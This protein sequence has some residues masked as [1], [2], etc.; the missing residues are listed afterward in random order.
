MIKVFISTPYFYPA[1]RAGGPVQSVLN[2]VNTEVEGVRYYVFTA[3]TDLNNEKLEVEKGKWIDFNERTKVYYS[4]SDNRSRTLLAEMERTG[5]ET[6]FIIGVFS[7]HFTIVPLYFGKPKHKIISAR[8]MLHTGALQQKALKKKIY[9]RI[10]ELFGL[11][12]KAVFHA[13][14][15]SEKKMIQLFFGKHIPVTVVPNLP[16]VVDFQP[17]QQKESGVLVLTTIAL[18]S[19]MKNIHLVLEALRRCEKEVVYHIYGP[20][21]DAT[22]WNL[23]KDIIVQM[24][25]NIRV[26]HHG[27]L[28]SAEVINALRQTHVFILPSV[29]ENFG[30]AIFE[31]LLAGRPV[32]TSHGTPWNNLQSE[33]AGWNADSSIE[34]LREAIEYFCKLNTEELKQWSN[35]A[36][37]YAEARLDNSNTIRNYVELFTPPLNPNEEN[38]H[39]EG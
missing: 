9:F 26:V 1:F 12:K 18:I 11:Q 36:R 6:I 25:V 29:S 34:A 28:P 21:K 16:R 22:Y 20:V 30:H 24:P 32:I 2:L 5:A 14:D 19:P 17:V 3:A 4:D 27:E 13:T 23:C 15:D 7:W 8:G 31:A 10:W 33:K 37:R 35:A 38:E 39:V